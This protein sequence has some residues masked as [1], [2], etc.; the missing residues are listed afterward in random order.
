MRGDG[1]NEHWYMG[2]T[3]C[4]RANVAYSLY[5]V[6]T[7]KDAPSSGSACL[8]PYYINSFFTTAGIESFGDYVG[9]D[10]EDAGASSECDSEEGDD[11]DNGYDNNNGNG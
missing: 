7:D 4:F 8:S 10:Y 11:N 9:I 5:G 6:K 1:G 3:Q 2:C